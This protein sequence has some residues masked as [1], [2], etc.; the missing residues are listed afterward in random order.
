[1]FP[2]FHSP[3]CMRSKHTKYLRKRPAVDKMPKL[4]RFRMRRQPLNKNSNNSPVCVGP[5]V[6]GVVTD[7]EEQTLR[8]P[9][10]SD[11]M[12]STSPTESTSVPPQPPTSPAQPLYTQPPPV[13]AVCSSPASMVA[14]SPVSQVGSKRK[15]NLDE[16]LVKQMAQLYECR[17]DLQKKLLQDSGD[18]CSRFGQTVADLLRRVPE[19]LRSDVMFN[20][21]RILYESRKQ[22]D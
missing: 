20:V 2:G 11:S 8:T 4:K 18:E 10:D 15:R 16:W 1:M 7:N 13:S 19:G 9:S 14:E 22:Q 6:S 12:P 5:D 21:H 17:T 3:W